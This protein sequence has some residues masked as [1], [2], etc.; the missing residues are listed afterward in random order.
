MLDQIS[1]MV[2]LSSFDFSF[3]IY[4]NTQ[5]PEQVAS[6]S[7][8]NLHQ[9]LE[10]KGFNQSRSCHSSSPK[11]N[12]SFPQFNSLISGSSASTDNTVDEEVTDTEGILLSFKSLSLSSSSVSV[13]SRSI[14]GVVNN[15]NDDDDQP[16]LF[17]DVR[18][19]G[20]SLLYWIFTF[21]T[22]RLPIIINGFQPL[23]SS[24][25]SV[26]H[27][28]LQSSQYRRYCSCCLGVVLTD[29]PSSSTDFSLSSCHPF[30]RLQLSQYRRYCSCCLGVVSGRGF[31]ALESPFLFRERE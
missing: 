12:Q 20:F 8:H 14:L 21:N 29:R 22:D 30:R 19:G 24:S 18:S 9:T 26:L 13:G 28:R 31:R 6:P 5:I 10:T 3:F 15:N 27:Q 2:G 23:F 1:A 4:S 25:F 11:L 16:D 17:C 7:K